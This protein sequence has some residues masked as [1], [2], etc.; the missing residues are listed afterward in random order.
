VSIAVNSGLVYLVF[1]IEQKSTARLSAAFSPHSSGSIQGSQIPNLQLPSRREKILEPS[2][3]CF[4]GSRLFGS[5]YAEVGRDDLSFLAIMNIN[6]HQYSSMTIFIND[7][8]G[9]S[10]GN[11]PDIH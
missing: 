1:P 2:M 9:G 11:A 10:G 6:I 5:V 3:Q 4:L 7:N 8:V